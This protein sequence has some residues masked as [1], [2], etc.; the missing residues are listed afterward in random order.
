[1]E[2]GALI[3][4]FLKALLK[5]NGCGALDLEGGWR[6]IFLLGLFKKGKTWNFCLVNF[7]LSHDRLTFVLRR[8]KQ[9]KIK[10]L[11]RTIMKRSGTK[12]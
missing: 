11:L 12:L 7:V 2:C 8:G 1:M 6:E 5:E 4:I 3:L 10:D 9:K